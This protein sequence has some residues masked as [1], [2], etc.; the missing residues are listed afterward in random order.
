MSSCDLQCRAATCLLAR[1][2]ALEQHV[3]ELEVRLVSRLRAKAFGE[4]GNCAWRNSQGDGNVFGA[5]PLKSFEALC[6]PRSR[7]T[8]RTSVLAAAL[9][10]RLCA[11]VTHRRTY[12]ET[13]TGEH[14]RGVSLQA[15]RENL[16]IPEADRAGAQLRAIVALLHVGRDVA[17]TATRTEV[18]VAGASTVAAAI[19]GTFINATVF[20]QASPFS[21]RNVKLADD[22]PSSTSDSPRRRP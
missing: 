10:R 3:D 18:A 11:F 1:R 2:G 13:S 14:R 8:S 22:E 19:R 9:I 4:H 16:D 15:R 5:E 17:V 21:A 7:T 12:L 6:L 20:E